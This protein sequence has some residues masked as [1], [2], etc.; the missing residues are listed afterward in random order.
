MTL[1][2]QHRQQIRKRG[3]TD[4]QVNWMVAAGFVRSLTWA[5]TAPPAER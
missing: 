5:A 1:S 4:E 2:T 3:F